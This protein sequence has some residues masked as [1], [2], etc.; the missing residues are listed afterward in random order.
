M[1]YDTQDDVVYHVIGQFRARK[2]KGDVSKLCRGYLASVTASVNRKAQNQKDQ[3]KGQMPRE[4][5]ATTT[6]KEERRRSTTSAKRRKTAHTT[7]PTQKRP[8]QGTSKVPL[9]S[10]AQQVPR[11]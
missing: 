5:T 9:K 4:H 8:T 7:E 11:Q 6:A 3:G 1:L 2:D 10:D